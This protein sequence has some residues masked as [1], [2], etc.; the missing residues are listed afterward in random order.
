MTRLFDVAV[1][2][3]LV[4]VFQRGAQGNKKC[5]EKVADVVFL[6]D[7]SY[8]IWQYQFQ[9]QLSF[10]KNMVNSFT[11]GSNNIRVGVATFSTN[12]RLDVA[13]NEH[14]KKHDLQRAIGQLQYM[15]GGTR[16]GDAIRF[17]H[18][19]MFT[20]AKGSR[21]WA[22]HIAILIT[23]GLSYRPNETSLQASIAR[24]KGIEMFAI[25]VGEGVDETELRAIASYP[26]A[27]HVFRVE[28]YGALK[29][30]EKA[31]ASK[32]CHK[33]NATDP[34][35]DDTE[36][37]E[38]HKDAARKRCGGKP[39]DVYFLLDSSSSIWRPQFESQVTFVSQLLNVFDL[40]PDRTRVGVGSYSDDV[41]NIVSFTDDQ[42]V[43]SV[44]KALQRSPYLT[45]STQTG[46][47]I[48]YVRTQG[49]SK[50]RQ[51]VAHVIIILTDGQSAN[52]THTLQE[53][54]KARDQGIYVFAVGIGSQTDVDE[55]MEIASDPDENFMFYVDDFGGL[56]NIQE[57]LAIKACDV[58]V[59]DYQGDQ[60][61]S[62]CR[63]TKP[64][65]VIFVYD[66]ASVS[67]LESDVISDTIRK[68]VEKMDSDPDLV[69]FGL[70]RGNC[71]KGDNIDLRTGAK[72]DVLL[73][74]LQKSH[75]HGLHHLLRKVR[76]HGFLAADD[77]MR[78]R[79]R[80][81]MVLFVGAK[82]ADPVAVETEMKRL[83]FQGVKLVVVAVDTAKENIEMLRTQAS[84]P[85]L[86]IE[87]NE[88]LRDSDEDLFEK[89]CD[90]NNPQD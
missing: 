53:A 16:T 77:E 48:H 61:L 17:A 57:L 67:K 12:V 55:L 87:T 39:A 83:N 79:A 27:S 59:P 2:T 74:L 35:P 71:F 89:F 40:G 38:K 13:L 9:T 75:H 81:V 73:N 25:G 56:K 86:E 3:F 26:D 68:L 34:T 90:I 47:A 88:H 21:P 11:I 36:E 80:K 52:T 37:E 8:S 29:H 5:S 20:P 66:S 63:I 44:K 46:K 65:D 41:H 18:T 19:Q 7:S 1:A 69:R 49:F 30:I 32:A 82:M 60:A 51:N 58:P 84:V 4:L 10:L 62:D 42:N 76:L 24:S 15:A 50:A 85:P 6:L 23:D 43:H 22:A 28:N 14:M 70:V 72:A 33:A 64:T 78:S 45:G 54:Q 31:L